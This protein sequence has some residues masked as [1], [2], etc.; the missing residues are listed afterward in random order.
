MKNKNMSSI[1]NVSSLM[2]VLTELELSSLMIMDFIV[3]LSE[4]TDYD[5]TIRWL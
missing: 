4:V 2:D 1:L 3:K 5:K